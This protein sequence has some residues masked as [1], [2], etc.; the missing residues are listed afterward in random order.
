MT[1]VL[2]SFITHQINEDMADHV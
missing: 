1:E 2:L